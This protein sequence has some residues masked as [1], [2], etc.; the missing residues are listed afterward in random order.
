[1]LVPLRLELSKNYLEIVIL[2]SH[3]NLS[4][5]LQTSPIGVLHVG[6][7]LAE[8]SQ[9]YKKLLHPTLGNVI[10]VESQSDKCEILRSSLDPKRNVIVEATIWD[11]SN[12]IMTFYETSNSESSSLLP[13][14]LHVEK[15]PDI[16]VVLERHV[17]TSRLD[18]LPQLDEID[19]DFINVDLQGVELRAIQ[20]LGRH[21]EKCRWIYVEV[22]KIELYENCAVVEDL[23][24]F[25]L[26]NGFQR[27]T[28]RW[29][30]DDGWGD[31]IYFR[32]EEISLGNRLVALF[33][34]YQWFFQ[35]LSG[36]LRSKIPERF[37]RVLR[38]ALPRKESKDILLE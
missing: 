13:L 20:S 27:I 8:E 24:K 12:Q 36:S 1:M 34:E 19:F 30:K 14:K 21:L 35:K 5:L 18:D 16:N 11:I 10:W 38:N 26:Q 4:R 17:L 23:D 33:L 3:K 22:N 29:V 7:H 32:V 28:T 6:A 37:R 9:A 25:L 31:A 15:Y 2:Y